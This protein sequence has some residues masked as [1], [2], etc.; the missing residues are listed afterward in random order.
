MLYWVHRRGETGRI[1]EEERVDM[2]VSLLS[3]GCQ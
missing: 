2:E 3:V 1:P